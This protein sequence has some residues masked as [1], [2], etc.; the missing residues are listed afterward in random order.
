MK[1]K[2][3]KIRNVEKSVCTCEQKI[4]YNY[5]F[6]NYINFGDDYDNAKSE[7]EK[8]KIII[9]CLNFNSDSLSRDEKIKCK[10]SI[11]TIESIL[12][13]NLENYLNAKKHIYSSYEEVGKMFLV[14]L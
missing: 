5:A 11:E 14:D 9:K 4:A 3:H 8:R 13:N 2:F 6:S 12:K 1:A 10:Y 7:A